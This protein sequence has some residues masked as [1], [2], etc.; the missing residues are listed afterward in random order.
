[1]HPGGMALAKRDSSEVKT[2]LRDRIYCYE[3]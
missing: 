3:I 1:V 2:N